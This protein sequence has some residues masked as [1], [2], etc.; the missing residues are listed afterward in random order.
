MIRR[1][2]RCVACAALLFG[3]A[4]SKPATDVAASAVDYAD[5]VI[6]SARVHTIDDAVPRAESVAITG[7]RITALGSADD[8]AELIGPDTRVI[9]A[10]GRLVLPGFVDS[11]THIFAGSFSAQR[12]NL[13][14]ADNLDTL[15]E[16]LFAIKD[17]NPGT[18]AIYARGWQN[19]IFPKDGPRKGLLDEI[20][21][22]RVVVLGSVD[23][24]STWFSSKAFEVA[25]VDAS[26]PD[27][28]PGVS[29]FERDPVTGELLGTAR[30]AASGLVTRK[31]ISFE[32]EAYKAALQRWL[33]QAA[34]AGL[35]TV[36]DAGASAPTQEEAYRIL[37]ELEDSDELTLRVY[38]SVGYQFG[39]D[40]PSARLLEYREKY[41]GEYYRPYSVKLYA[42]G[43]PEGHTAFLLE[44]YVDQ[45]DSVGEPMIK[46]D[47]MAELIV[48]SFERDVPVHVHAIG[49]AAV[50]MT[51][52]AIEAA[53][54]A[55]GKYDVPAAIA[56]MDF[57]SPADIPRFADLNVVAQ[58]SIQ[59]AAADPS[60][61]NIGGFVGMDVVEDAYP[62]KTLIESGAVQSF[63]AD[64]P[65]AAYLSTYEPLTLLEVAVTRQLPGELEMPVRKRSERLTVDEAIRSLTIRSAI[66][67]DADDEIGSLAVGKK[68]DLILLDDDVFEMPAHDIHKARVALTMMDGRVVHEDESGLAMR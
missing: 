35:T 8:T 41:T 65:A 22:D 9:D 60:Y 10:R 67:L 11:H 49:G 19:H 31:V 55:T 1:T 66:Q 68:A 64:W 59:W 50:R 33:P 52:D 58:T 28:E 12:I 24:H 42:D 48:D 16:F 62:V 34:A 53:R 47:R 39:D 17:Q 43:V 63:G 23:G 26:T 57:V 6:T 36:F 18:E 56:H 21:G 44:P 13:S 30:E 38:G 32:R 37:A 54:E 27:P 4:C 15:K 46:P 40:D 2:I 25:G 61:E 14:L 5:V 20:F 29:F 51:L 45:P 7:D 3:A